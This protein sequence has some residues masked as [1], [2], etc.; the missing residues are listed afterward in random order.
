MLMKDAGQHSTFHQG[1]V[2]GEKKLLSTGWCSTE[3]PQRREKFL[4]LCFP[5]R[6]VGHRERAEYPP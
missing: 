4:S 1:F 5:G 6:W 3:L 2:S